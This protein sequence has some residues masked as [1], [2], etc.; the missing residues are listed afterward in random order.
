MQEKL[1]PK[2]APQIQNIRALLLDTRGP[3]IR[4]GKLKNDLSGHETITLQKGNTITLQT[5]KKY[6]EEGSTETDLFINYAGLSK[7]LNPGMKVLLDDGV[8]ILTVQEVGKDSVVCS[9]AV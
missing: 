7:S 1:S 4:S 3:E 6:E 2:G 5:S 8:V 9:I